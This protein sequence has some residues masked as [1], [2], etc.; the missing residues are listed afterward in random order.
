MRDSQELKKD[1]IKSRKKIPDRYA[2]TKHLYL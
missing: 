1:I 2:I